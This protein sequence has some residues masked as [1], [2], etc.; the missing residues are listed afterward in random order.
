M[1]R[2]KQNV[3]AYGKSWSPV[4]LPNL[5]K[6][7]KILQ[8]L[9]YIATHFANSLSGSNAIMN[10]I[11]EKTELQNELQR[12]GIKLTEEQTKDVINLLKERQ[13]ENSIY[14]QQS[15]LGNIQQRSGIGNKTTTNINFNNAGS[16]LAGI[17]QQ[18]YAQNQLNK[19]YEYFKQNSISKDSSTI[20]KLTENKTVND[21][22]GSATK[23]NLAAD[24]LQTAADTFKKGIDVFKSLFTSG[25]NN[26]VNTYENTFSNISVRTGL[27]RS[28][29]YG[30]QANTNNELGALGLRDNIG[31]SEV[32]NMWN[33]LASNGFSQEEMF[34]NAIDTVLTQKIVP[35]LDTTSQQTEILNDRLGGDFYKQIRGISK[36]NLDIAGNNYATQDVLNTLLDKVTPMSDEALQNLAQGSTQLTG[37]ANYLMSKE[38]GSLT[39][40]QA[41]SVITQLYKQQ[42][43][44]DQIM[45]SGTTLEKMGLI[46]NLATNTDIYD[47]LQYKQAAANI[48]SEGQRVM[49]MTPGYG[50]TMSG[51][52]TNII[53]RAFGSDF[54]MNNAFIKMNQAGVDN[55]SGGNLTKE[56]LEQYAKQ[57]TNEF[58]SGDNQTNKTLQNITVENLANELAVGEEWMGHWTDV[59]TTAIKGI[60]T[61]LLTKIVGGV[62]GKG[63]G[64]LSGL[65]GVSALG[66]SSGLGALLG[67]AGPIALGIGAVAGGISL[68]NKISANKQSESL[69]NT[70]NRINNLYQQNQNKGMSTVDNISD[71]WNNGQVSND[72]GVFLGGGE[73]KASFNTKKQTVIGSWY[74]ASESFEDFAND[75]GYLT[76][77]SKAG[78]SIL[79]A[80]SWMD[81]DKRQQLGLTPSMW[82]SGYDE[83]KKALDKYGWSG[84]RNAEAYNK[85]KTYALAQYLNQNQ[86][87]PFNYAMAALSAALIMGNHTSDDSIMGPLQTYFGSAL[88]TDKNT[89]TQVLEKNGITEAKYL[90]AI[91]KIF[92]DKNVDYWLMTNGGDVMTYPSSDELKQNFNLHRQG[93]N[94]VPYDDYPALLHQGEAVLTASTSNE[95]RN[96]VDTY[97]ETNN[98]SVNFEAI[99][100]AQTSD[101]LNKLDQ[102][103]TAINNNS[104]NGS[105][106]N[107]TTSDNILNSM[108]HIRNTRTI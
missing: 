88:V 77:N 107:N 17:A 90:S 64:A 96:L 43:Y 95:L 69:Q 100:Q 34:K 93:L 31:T 71:I 24:I 32:Q 4:D 44:S 45:S 82:L 60:K 8:R 3:E 70:T 61:I 84:E 99:I 79:E 37:Y 72:T 22:K 11:N 85:I 12:M 33:T 13:K 51:L 101:L 106:T 18:K 9:D 76:N 30:K 98:Q 59:I 21:I 91:Y 74:E 28:Q 58:S 92:G 29:Y 66:S 94:E 1:P 41:T 25:L 83:A 15:S 39:K 67:T 104:L 42:Q 57:A 102:V 7:V 46:R 38:G 78:G 108:I 14:V 53:G 73:T 54:N 47:P 23:F 27:T 49:A 55:T 26:Q 52:V 5:E 105:T 35:Y 48:A 50:S 103:I 86:N 36:A 75:Q 19:N 20:T 80:F 10:Q 68:L 81:K 63:I 16:V 2:K 62:I 87:I 97:R 56:Q 40:D 6:A 65:G 89:L